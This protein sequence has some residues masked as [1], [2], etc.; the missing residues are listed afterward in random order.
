MVVELTLQDLVREIDAQL[1]EAVGTHDLKP[2]DVKD[3]NERV[4]LDPFSTRHGSE[5][6]RGRD[7]R[8]RWRDGGEFYAAVRNIS[9][10]LMFMV[11]PVSPWAGHRMWPRN[12][13]DEIGVARVST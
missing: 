10:R 5:R 11:C 12:T 8:G 1:L 3:A 2:E 4:Y 13:F 7:G 9:S 6:T